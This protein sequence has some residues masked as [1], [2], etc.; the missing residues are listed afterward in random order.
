MWT[1]PRRTLFFAMGFHYL[2]IT[3][4]FSNLSVEGHV[5]VEVVTVAI[6][7]QPQVL[8]KHML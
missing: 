6:L 1:K 8:I 2:G 4:T 5:V 7:Q 3:V